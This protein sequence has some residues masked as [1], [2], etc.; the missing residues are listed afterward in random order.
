MRARFGKLRKSGVKERGQALVEFTIVVLV[1]L[2]FVFG[3]LDMARLF[4]SW[5]NV[6]H[7]ARE[8]ARFGVTGLD[9]CTFGGVT[10]TNDRPA[11][12][13]KTVKNA[14]TGMLN[15][16]LNGTGITVTCQSWTYSSGY[17]SSS[18]PGAA[19][20]Q[21]TTVGSAGYMGRQ[22]DAEEVI[23]TYNH[24][25][26]TPLLQF[27]A[28]SGIPLVGRQRMINEPFGPC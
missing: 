2:L 22:C 14:T 3:I 18:T 9:D 13:V 7:A 28:P 26:I 6:Q 21:F 10:T 23:V 11:C 25:F 12:T 27:A 1:F 20:C 17:S 16:G 15:G 19:A 5:T 24:K 4:E 8:G